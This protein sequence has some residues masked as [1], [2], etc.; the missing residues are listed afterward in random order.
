MPGRHALVDTTPVSARVGV[1]APEEL[2]GMTHEHGEATARW[3]DSASVAFDQIDGR[4]L[5]SEQPVHPLARKWLAHDTRRATD[6]LVYVFD[7]G[8]D[9]TRAAAVWAYLEAVVGTR[10]RHVLPIDSAGRERGGLIWASTPYP[11][12]HST[13]LTL[14]GLRRGKGGVLTVYEVARAME[15][16]L[17][18]VLAA[19]E[20]GA[21]H[22][23]ISADE[24]LVSPRGTLLVE[25]YGLARAVGPLR[26]PADDA[27]RDEVR[28]V[29]E[30][31]WRLLTGAEPAERE[32]FAGQAR[33]TLDRGWVAWLERGLDPAVGF[34]CA[35]EA[36]SA[37]PGRGT[38]E[39]TVPPGRA[40]GWLGRLSSAVSPRRATEA[41]V[42]RKNPGP[43]GV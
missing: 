16:L 39:V 15:Q 2:A 8:P 28:S 23:P 24:V 43:G 6:C 26:S 17:D 12:H 41:G 34:S 29:V 10:R 32:V 18:A 21:A 22:G 9:E 5:L 1:A 35:G 7:P 4:R 33:R 27:R 20:A 14:D 19:H 25:M 40:F 3:S 36:L 31:A 38:A 42:S 13:L 30:T 11:G 37:L